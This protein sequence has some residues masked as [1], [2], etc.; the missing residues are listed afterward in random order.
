M[1]EVFFTQKLILKKDQ[2][3]CNQKRWPKRT[4]HVR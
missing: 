4:N 3:G 2:N 1:G